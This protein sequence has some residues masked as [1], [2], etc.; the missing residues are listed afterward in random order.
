MRYALEHPYI[1][2]FLIISLIAAIN[3]NITDLFGYLKTRALMK[4]LNR[5]KP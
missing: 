4:P 3:D 1:T 5:D 2:A